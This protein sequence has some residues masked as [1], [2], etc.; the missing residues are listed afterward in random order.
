MTYKITTKF[1]W[2]HTMTELTNC[3]D[4]WEGISE[5]KVDSPRG[6]Y[7]QSQYQDEVQRT[8][9]L[10][11]TKYGSQ[12]ELIMGLQNRATDNLRVLFIAVESMRM[13]DKRG[14]GKVVESAYL[15]L[16]GMSERD[17]YRILG[18]SRSDT[19]SRIE[20]IYKELLKRFHPDTINGDEK[21][22]KEIITAM[23]EIRK[24]KEVSKQ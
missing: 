14:I 13:N 12:V 15:Q 9:K 2:A 20:S 17:P 1:S 21:K 8:V 18:V 7:S 6:A 19:L 22:T 24:E 5:W 11:Y 3:M 23:N 10:T 16:A 4:S